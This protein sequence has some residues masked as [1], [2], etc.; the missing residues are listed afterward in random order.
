LNGTL[1]IL[2]EGILNI[3]L[4]VEPGDGETDNLFHDRSIFDGYS[5]L[6]RRLKAKVK[7]LRIGKVLPGFHEMAKLF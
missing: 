3:L 7:F 6:N 2:A 1:L 5:E 4:L